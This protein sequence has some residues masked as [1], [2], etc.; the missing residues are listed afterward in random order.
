M[1][2]SFETIEHHDRHQKYLLEIKRVLKKDG[3]LIISS[4]DKKEYS[5]LPGYKNQFHVKEL[6][7]S[8]FEKL[9]KDNFKYYTM[10]GQRIKYGS[11][12]SPI[13]QKEKNH[14]VC[15]EKNNKGIVDEES[16]IFNPLYF[17]SLA[18]NEKIPQGFLSLYEHQ[19]TMVPA[20]ELEHIKSNLDNILNSKSWQITKPL[21]RFKQILD[22]LLL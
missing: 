22:R 5:D 3:L 13:N 10:L 17:I 9:I 7:Y 18:S 12:I 11:Y 8:E 19:K 6:Y 20:I 1:V 4:P 14:F 16:S 2:I 15:Y 21:R